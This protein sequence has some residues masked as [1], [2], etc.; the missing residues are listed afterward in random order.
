MYYLIGYAAALN[1]KM[2]EM[3]LTLVMWEIFGL[4]DYF[5]Q[6]ILGLLVHQ[7]IKAAAVQVTMQQHDWI[8][9]SIEAR[10]PEVIVPVCHGVDYGLILYPGHVI[11]QNSRK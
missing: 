8:K 2:Q 9:L 3:H 7:T 1:V 11:I 10:S 5:T 4:L 6:G